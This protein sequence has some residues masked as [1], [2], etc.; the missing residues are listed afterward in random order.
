MF[1]VH[2]HSGKKT[3]IKI[4]IYPYEIA[5]I[6]WINIGNTASY[7]SFV[8]STKNDMTKCL[9]VA[10]IF[11]ALLRNSLSICNGPDEVV[12]GDNNVTWLLKIDLTR[13]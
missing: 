11:S 10:P 7:L 1:V 2:L 3:V 9:E 13:H 12:T 4:K 6:I 5:C 8:P